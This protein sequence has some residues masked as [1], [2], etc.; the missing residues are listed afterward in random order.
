MLIGIAGWIVLGLV[1]G[2]IAAKI[3]NLRGDDPR[4][5]IIIGGVGGAIGGFL[6]SHYTHTDVTSFNLTSL[7]YAAVAAAGA[8][9]IW[10]TWRLMQPAE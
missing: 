2:F 6:F 7:F 8:L 5:G 4:M 3:V 9:A 10:H 1:V